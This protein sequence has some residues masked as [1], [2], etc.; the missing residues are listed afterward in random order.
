MRTS[1]ET[2]P[3]TAELLGRLLPIVR[4]INAVLDPDQLLPTI[5]RQSW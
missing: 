4:E 2:A 3:L 5:A 1:P